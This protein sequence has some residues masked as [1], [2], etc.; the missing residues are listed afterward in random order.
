MN[1]DSFLKEQPY[2]FNIQNID[3]AQSFAKYGILSRNSAK[4]KNIILSDFSDENVQ[5]IRSDRKIKL[6]NDKE[7][8]LHDTVCLFFHPHNTTTFIAQ[9]R[10]VEDPSDIIVYCVDTKKIIE[11]K[12]LSIA[13]CHSNAARENA[14][15]FN[16]LDNLNEIDW[17]IMYKKGWHQRKDKDFEEW[18]SVKSSEFFVFPS[19]EEKYITHILCASQEQRKIT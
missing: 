7:V 3:T 5:E 19:I 18:R 2:L 8:S 6:S 11:D 17:E 4:E 12:R 1:Y 15:F 16:S 13:F 10:M 14:K 9:Q